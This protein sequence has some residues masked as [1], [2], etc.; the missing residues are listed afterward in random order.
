MAKEVTLSE[1]KVMMGVFETAIGDVGKQKRTIRTT[2]GEI[3]GTFSSI[4]A[5]WQSPA[6]ETFANLT[7]DFTTAA[8]N[9]N[10]LLDDIYTRM[11][12]T[13]QNYLTVE[14][15]AEKNLKGQES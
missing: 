2:L 14:Q 3:A 10:D 1:F 5:D 11:G 9:L 12:Q 6:A 15:Q 7:T 4:E 8:K 13:Y